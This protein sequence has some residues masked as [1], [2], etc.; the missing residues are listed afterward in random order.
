MYGDFSRINSLAEQ[1]FSAV[2]SQQGRVQLDSDQNEAT[3]IMLEYLRTLTTDIIGPFGGHAGR[4]GF[5]VRV[6]EAKSDVAESAD[7]VL[8]PGHYYVYGLR[9]EVPDVDQWG[10]E[11]EVS[12]RGRP[13]LG[14]GISGLPPVPF[15]VSLAVWERTVSAVQDPG[16]LEPALGFDPPDTT[17]RSQVRWQMVVN[18]HTPDGDPVRGDESREELTRRFADFHT[19]PASAGAVR[20]RAGGA[21]SAGS[22]PSIMPAETPYRGV[23]NQLYRVEIHRGGPVGE[24]TWKWSRDNGSASF[25]IDSLEGN[26]AVLTGLGRDGRSGIQVGDLVEIIDDTW[27]PF[28]T[29]APLVKVG[30]IDPAT[31]RVTLIGQ[32]DVSFQGGALHP[33]LRRWDQSASSDLAPDNALAVVESGAHEG[34]LDLEDG[35]QVQF[36]EP[37]E[38]R[39]HT[40]LRGDYWLI[41][42]RTTGHILWP[43]SSEHPAA[44][45]AH[46]PSRYFAPL[47]MVTTLQEDPAPVDL[48]SLFT[49]LTSVGAGEKPPA[50][51]EHPPRAGET[52]I[53]ERAWPPRR[54]RL[55]AVSEKEHGRTWELREP[56]TS[57]GR[58]PTSQIHLED[59]SVSRPHASITLDGERLSIQNLSARN[60][61]RVNGTDATEVIEITSGDRLQVGAIE[62]LVEEVEPAD[63]QARQQGET[64]RLSHDEGD[65]L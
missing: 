27:A 23:E 59:L 1:G 13:G 50:E 17:V 9:C 28:G 49:D 14:S 39:K 12:Y 19:R 43:G 46:G 3:S 2:W 4:A 61:L 41:P 34:W 45:T 36:V 54:F 20:A 18:A 62:L 35:V 10:R 22:D 21:T 64:E 44:I 63:P 26:I 51:H 47:A 31:R 42:A 37:R 33:F 5:R 16:L 30:H 60:P 48:R 38:G 6:V 55:V 25:G 65:Y 40:Y 8:S 15:I 53:S 29:P 56:T 24:A 32:I 57:I 7:L 11:V 58:D 52:V